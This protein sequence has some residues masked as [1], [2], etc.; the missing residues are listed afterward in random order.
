VARV[1]V[2]SK[3]KC[4][5]NLWLKPDTI[6]NSY[7]ILKDLDRDL[8]DL[9]ALTP[10][11]REEAPDKES[12]GDSERTWSGGEVRQKDGVAVIEDLT[13][14]PKLMYVRTD[15]DFDGTQFVYDH[16]VSYFKGHHV[17]I[18][19]AILNRKNA[20]E[21]KVRFAFAFDNLLAPPVRDFMMN[22]LPKSTEQSRDSVSQVI[23][24]PYL[25]NTTIT[26]V[27]VPSMGSP[28]VDRGH[29]ILSVASFSDYQSNL[30][31]A[32]SEFAYEDHIKLLK[33]LEGLVLRY[34]SDQASKR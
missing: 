28:R 26:S 18:E 34:I 20:T 4:Q 15:G 21:C 17:M 5:L 9:F 16:L 8:A 29:F 23:V 30:V 33:Q 12:E 24:Q 2:V 7:I 22:T 13:L 6:P 31:D 1:E 19:D 10:K 11:P 3:A 14:S 32:F 27:I 25:L